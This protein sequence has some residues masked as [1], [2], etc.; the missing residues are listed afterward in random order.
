MAKR[1]PVPLQPD[2]MARQIKPPQATEAAA[3]TTPPPAKKKPAAKK[4]APA[5]K[6][7]VTKAKATTRVVRDSFSM[8]AD[9]YALI[10]EL[11]DA[12]LQQGV[13]MNKGEILRAGL[14][15]LSGMSDRAL[16][17]AAG[18][19]VKVKTGRPKEK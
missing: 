13:A 9:D 12:C 10:D 2:L 6:K 4:K 5:R 16:K 7:P 19:V 18:K 14:L 17:R 8:P 1:N 15:A 3:P 11:R